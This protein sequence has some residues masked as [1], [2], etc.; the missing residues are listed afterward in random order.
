MLAAGGGTLAVRQARSRSRLVALAT[1]A[2]GDHLNCAITFNLAERPIALED[3]ARRYGMPYG[4]M[5]SF[6][7]PPLT[8]PPEPLDRHSCVYGGHRFAHVVMRYRGAV[9]S[10]LVTQGG[11]PS[12]PQLE[13]TSGSL[14]VAS[15]RA[16]DFVGFVVSSLAS[17]EV[18]RLAQAIAP[19][20]D[21]HLSA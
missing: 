3:A 11:G 19:S 20:L 12:E 21:R 17:D 8:P 10:L 1:T 2:A 6:D 5:A 13:T 7:M 4:Q 15:L 18:L 16:G 9:T 14:A